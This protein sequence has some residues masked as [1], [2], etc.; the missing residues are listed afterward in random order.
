MASRGW[1]RPAWKV[2]SAWKKPRTW[3]WRWKDDNL[4]TVCHDI[5]E[6]SD[7]GDWAGHRQREKPACWKHSQHGQVWSICR[8]DLFWLKNMNL[9]TQEVPGKVHAS[10]RLSPPLPH[11]WCM[12]LVDRLWLV[13][14]WVK[15]SRPMFLLM[16]VM[17]FHCKIL[18]EWIN[19]KNYCLGEHNQRV[20]QALV[21]RQIRACPKV[22]QQLIWLECLRSTLQL[23]RKDGGH[24]ALGDIQDS[25]EELK[26]Y[27][28]TVFKQWDQN[29]A[30]KMEQTSQSP[31]SAFLRWQWHPVNQTPLVG[32]SCS[33]LVASH[34]CEFLQRMSREPM[35]RMDQLD[36]VWFQIIHLNSFI[37]F[38]LVAGGEGDCVLSQGCRQCPRR[39]CEGQTESKAG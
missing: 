2:R 4:L 34:G 36:K 13:T 3:W 7:L 38:H 18:T 25:I 30:A 14:G 35:A 10:A 33:L 5:S 16:Y 29:F 24:R 6:K 8:I 17:N 23:F 12:W 26:Y 28:R 31:C 15:A 32:F 9:P 11:C 39:G 27:R 37:S 1:P 21:S 19:V 20:D 22:N